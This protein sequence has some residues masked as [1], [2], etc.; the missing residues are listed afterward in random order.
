MNQRKWDGRGFLVR[1]IGLFALL[2]FASVMAVQAESGRTDGNLPLPAAQLMKLLEYGEFEI[3]SDEATGQSTM[4]SRRLSLIFSK[5]PRKIDVK[6][7]PALKSGGEGWNN[8]P[9]R[10]VAAYVIQ[11]W[12]L[13][14]E[15]YVVPPTT[16]RCISLAQY[17]MIEPDAKPN[18]GPFQCVY[19]TLSAWLSNVEMPDRVYDKERFARDK[20]YAYHLANMNLHNYLINHQ[21]GVV[22]NYLFSTDPA[23]PRVFSIDNGMSQTTG[24][25]NIF[26]KHWNT[27]RVPA[28]PRRSIERLRKVTEDDLA[29]LG[30]LEQMDVG[31]DG[32]LRHS[33]PGEN[34]NPQAGSR[35]RSN[36]IQIGLTAAEI[37]MAREKLQTLLRQVDQGK[38]EL[39]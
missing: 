29:R 23:N 37:R 27:I 8:S 15:D 13:D 1:A 2:N 22:F 14:P 7:K 21:D 18:I 28:L 32:V 16:T 19:G 25:Q 39:Y 9:R 36:T 12:F 4:G 11:Q 3:F 20:R 10:E 34:L 17:R 33:E 35:V 31:P 38:W 6:W 26:V 5:E 24:L 30:V